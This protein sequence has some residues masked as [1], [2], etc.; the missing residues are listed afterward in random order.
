[1]PFVG[2]DGA[3]Y[4][5]WSNFNSPGSNLSNTT[6]NSYQ[7]LLAKSTDGGNSFSAP[8][9]VANYNDLPDCLTYQGSDPFRSCVPEKGPTTNSVFRA[10]NYPSGS[11]NP[12]N[13]R[14]V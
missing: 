5:A 7:V 11:V 9:K 2:P 4:V 10:T 6:D 14:Q 8:I 12:H 1:D 13:A 3:L